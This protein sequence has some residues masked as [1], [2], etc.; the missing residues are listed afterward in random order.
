[1]ALLRIADT[2]IASAQTRHFGAEESLHKVARILH[3]GFW[4]LDST[5]PVSRGRFQVELHSRLVR[6]EIFAG[7]SRAHYAMIAYVQ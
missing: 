6:V 3:I 7:L 1:V 5:K 4:Y 2:T